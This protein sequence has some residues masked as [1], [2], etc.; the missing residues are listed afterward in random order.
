MSRAH[1]YNFAHR[2]LPGLLW[3][4]PFLFL[5]TLYGDHA[6]GFLFTLWFQA[7]KG[8]DE[9]DVMLPSEELRRDLF[10][11]KGGYHAAVVS[12]PEPKFLT[13]AYMVAIVFR[14][15][16]KR[17]LLPK[18]PPVFRYFTLEY[19]LCDGMQT[20]RTVLCEWT[21]AVHGNYGTGPL[22][23]PKAF[24]GAIESLLA[25]RGRNS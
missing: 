15:E 18:L 7:S 14:P 8:L 17:L 11:L 9:G 12:L 25:K 5:E 1:H 2:V 6:S 3:A 20:V 4:N 13:E 21:Q 19:G 24:I 22:A 10:D 16:K 23:N